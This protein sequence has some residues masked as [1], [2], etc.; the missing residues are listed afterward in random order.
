M[1]SCP[2]PA[3]HTGSV[4]CA[5]TSRRR[6]DTVPPTNRVVEECPVAQVFN[7]IS[8]AVMTA[9]PI[10][11]DAF[12]LGF[13]SSEGIVGR[14]SG[15]FGIETCCAAEIAEVRLTVSQQG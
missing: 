13:A 5:V 15:V 9:T 1:Q 2:D 14:A 6:G 7:G 11:L 8:H 10:D 12:A 4:C 3:D